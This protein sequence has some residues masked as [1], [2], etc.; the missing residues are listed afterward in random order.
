[1]P[2]LQGESTDG[3]PEHLKYGWYNMDEMPENTIQSVKEIVGE[4]KELI[5]NVILNFIISYGS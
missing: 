4:N 2:I 3:T 5:K 1:M